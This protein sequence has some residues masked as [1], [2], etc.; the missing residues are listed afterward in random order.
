MESQASLAR[1]RDQR[2]NGR[3]EGSTGRRHWLVEGA[4]GAFLVAAPCVEGFVRRHTTP[5]A[6]L[7]AGLVLMVWAVAGYLYFWFLFGGM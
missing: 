4:I 1:T 5:S 6:D 7:V 3:G 2:Q